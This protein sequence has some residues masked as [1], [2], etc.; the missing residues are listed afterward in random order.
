MRM[1][2]IDS[3]IKRILFFL[4]FLL[5]FYWLFWSVRYIFSDVLPSISHTFFL[6]LL[7]LGIVS[8]IIFYKSLKP[9]VIKI[10]KLLYTY[11]YFVIGILFIGQIVISVFAQCLP[12]GDASILYKV[13]IA[14]PTHSGSSIRYFSLFPNNFLI[15]ITFKILN[16]IVT[17]P[18]L[19]LTVSILNALLID[20]GI[21]LLTGLADHLKGEKLARI[22]FLESL[23]LF[24]L[25]PH[26]LSFYSDPATFFLMA[27]LCYLVIINLDK[28]GIFR[29][30]AIGLLFSIAYKIR[31]PIFIYLIALILLIIYRLIFD[32][33]QVN[34]K[35]LFIRSLLLLLGML[36]MIFAIN[37]YAENQKFVEYDGK[38]TMS[39]WFFVDLGL[40]ATGADHAAVSQ[41][42]KFLDAKGQ[43]KPR[44][45]LEP[46]LKEDVKKRFSRFGTLGLI[47]HQSTKFKIFT[48]DGSLGWTAENVLKEQNI[49][50]T[51][52]TNSKFGQKIRSVIYVGNPHYG[53]Y[54]LYL[55]IA[56][57]IIILG[58]VAYFKKFRQTSNFEF[59]LQ[60]V[61]FGV[62]LYLSI[63]EAGRSRYLIQFLP[64]I[65]MLSSIGYLNYFNNRQNK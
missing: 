61:L 29:W 27:L 24:G 52:F 39:P 37:F 43:F 20:G 51:K 58:L 63:F 11:R 12:N 15:F 44:S 28:A 59:Y 6:S 9:L 13:A 46:Q 38:Y 48:Q 7:V 34:L 47:K 45:E 17:A 14:P 16:G 5:S 19:I 32:K 21:L 42:V 64:A 31:V 56:W 3:G 57:S 41:D 54:A 4:L 30:F 25:Q 18:H 50:K 23:F 49:V 40:T 33:K 8:G 10:F 2:H 1:Q 22:V 36:T 26:F 60:I 55:Q 53:N 62:I 35:R 65:I